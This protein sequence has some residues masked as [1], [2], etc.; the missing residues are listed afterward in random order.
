MCGVGFLPDVPIA[1]RGVTLISALKVSVEGCLG[2]NHSGDR[3]FL[4]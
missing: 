4:G 2:I 3:L 1:G